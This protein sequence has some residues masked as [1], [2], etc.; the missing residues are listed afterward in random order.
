M[1]FF[2]QAVR[3]PLIVRPPGGRPARVETAPVQM[4]D[5]AATFRDI[6][7]ANAIVGSAA[8]SLR[9]TVEG[10]AQPFRQDVIISENFGFAMFLQGPH[11]LVVYEDDIKPVQFFDLARDPGED[12]NLI[13]D[14]AYASIIGEIMQTQ[15]CPFFTVKPLRPHPDIVKRQGKKVEY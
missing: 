6:A 11:K 9:D 10:D 13:D 15:V 12:R 1:A 3:V 5:L 8:Y 2:E 4:M 7:D 14:P